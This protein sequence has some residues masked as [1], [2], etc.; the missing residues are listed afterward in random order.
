[1][2]S[3][4]LEQFQELCAGVW[5]DR[6]G[7]LAGRG[8]LT[9]DAALVRA[10]YWRL[11]KAGVVKKNASDNYSLPQSTLTYETVVG[12]VLEMNAKPPFNGVPFLKELCGRYQSEVLA[13]N[14]T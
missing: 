7:V 1:M 3:I 14:L 9:G 8:F 13:A 5:R 12:C 4:N 6:A 2:A 10:V 11:C